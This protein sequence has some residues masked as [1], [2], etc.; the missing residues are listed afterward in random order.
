[1]YGFHKIKNEGTSHEFRHPEFKR[2]KLDD[3]RKIKRKTIETLTKEDKIRH[4]CRLLVNEYH[5]LEKGYFDLGQTLGILGSQTRQIAEKNK[6]LMGQLY[7]SRKEYEL[8]MKKLIFLFF[9]LI[10]NYTPELANLI[11]SSL[12]KANLINGS[13]SKL[14]ASPD[15]FR[16][17]LQKIV[18]RLIFN[19]NK[20]DFFLDNLLNIFS[21]Y[22]TNGEQ[23]DPDVIS[24]YK[25]TMDAF[26]KDEKVIPLEYINQSDVSLVDNHDIKSLNPL[27]LERNSSFPDYLQDSAFMLDEMSVNLPSQIDLDD[28]LPRMDDSRV[29]FT[30]DQHSVSDVESLHLFSPKNE[31]SHL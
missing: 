7:L 31:D 6:E 10:E 17:F 4:D 15:Q 27:I 29:N 9:V 5:K 24:N 8:R 22:V 25:T 12:T 2:G 3:I 23:I 16:T 28:V 30:E 18:Q 1:M 26:L 21:S 13:E 20:N 19:K 11:K 14:T